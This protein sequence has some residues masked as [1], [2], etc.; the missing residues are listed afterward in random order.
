M[1]RNKKIA[2]TIIAAG[3]A[4]TLAACSSPG[5][6]EGDN[7][8]ET[9]QG[10]T[11][12]T[13]K[14]GL[15]GPMSGSAAV[16]GKG[17]N[18]I[19]A[20]YEEINARGGINGRQIEVI[21]EDDECSGETARLAVTKLIQQDKVF[22][23]HGGECSGAVTAAMP[24]I[25]DSGIP[26]IIA[27]A[28]AHSLV[29]P[30]TVNVFHGWADNTGGTSADANF[31]TSF[32]EDN[33]GAAKIAIVTQADDWGKGWTD[34]FKAA[35]EAS[36]KA[37]S[38]EIVTE[39]DLAADTTDATAQVQNLKSADVDLAV[40]YAY[41]DPM[42]VFLRNK[43]QQGLDIPVITGQGTFP[44]DQLDRLGNAETV[45]TFFSAYCMADTLDSEALAPFKDATAKHYPNDEF[46][47]SSMLGAS[48]VPV[49]E[50][51][52]T[53]LGDDLNWESWIAQA[54][55]IKDFETGA[56]AEPISYAPFDEADPNTRLGVK[57]CNLAYLNEEDPDSGIVVIS[58]EWSEWADR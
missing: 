7:G 35:L 50:K 55:T 1:S 28:A 32:A 18:T 56:A 38:I 19:H 17:I 58:P 5:A 29:N 30:P 16:F 44:E 49:N 3:L 12:D 11:A 4:I 25:K 34:S 39:M 42:S 13:I 23:L 40:V 57:T 8:A 52:L 53:D 45:G 48:G 46:D 51:I 22:M 15:F 33:G 10:V 36:G 54:E 14:I 24:I 37:D 21:I 41:P 6:E 27:G 31:V 26:Y 47:L 20:M 9:A 43:S 2:S